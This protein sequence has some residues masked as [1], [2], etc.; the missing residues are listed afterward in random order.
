[1]KINGWFNADWGGYSAW[2]LVARDLAP[3]RHRLTI[4]LLDEKAEASTGHHFEVRSVLAAG[5]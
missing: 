5:L 3:G 1:V 2:E 4:Q